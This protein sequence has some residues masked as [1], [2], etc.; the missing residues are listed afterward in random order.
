MFFLQSVNWNRIDYIYERKVATKMHKIVKGTGGHRL[1][2]MFEMK[3]SRRRGLQLLVRRL[4]TEGERNT[5][6]YRGTIIWNS[7]TT[8]VKNASRKEV[9]KRIL[10][11]ECNSIEN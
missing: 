10:T 1:R 6:N 9:F 2:E 3:V 7:L 11:K 5:V 8:D 4:V